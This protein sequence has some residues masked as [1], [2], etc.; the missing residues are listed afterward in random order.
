VWTNNLRHLERWLFTSEQRHGIGFALG[1]VDGEVALVPLA[2][3]W[4]H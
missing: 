2:T 1:G 3:A 4:E